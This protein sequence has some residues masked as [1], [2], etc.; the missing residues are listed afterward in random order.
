MGIMGPNSRDGV[1][2]VALAMVAM[3]KHFHSTVGFAKEDIWCIDDLVVQNI[4]D[5]GNIMHPN[6]SF[7]GGY[8]GNHQKITI[9]LGLVGLPAL[10]P[11]GSAMLI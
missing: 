2:D 5:N 7:K 1:D 9:G 4:I 8:K 3:L 11:H 6:F 10:S